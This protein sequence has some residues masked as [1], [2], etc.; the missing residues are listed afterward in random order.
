MDLFWNGTNVNPAPFA[1]HETGHAKPVAMGTGGL[2]LRADGE[3]RHSISN[4]YKLPA[5]EQATR[6]EALNLCHH[7]HDLP[8]VDGIS[9]QVKTGQ[10]LGLLGPNGAGK[11]TTLRIL[12]GVMVPESGVV[13]IEDKSL[14]QHPELSRKIGFLPDQAPLYGDL[15]I[16]EQL[17]FAAGLYAIPAS[18]RKQ[19][20]LRVI[21]L[22]ELETVCDKRID[23]LSKGFRRR[24][25]LAQALLHEPGILIL[26]EP[27]DGLDPL[28]QMAFRKLIESL[29]AETAIVISTHNL[30]EVKNLCTDVIIMDRGSSLF[31]AAVRDIEQPLEQLFTQLIYAGD[32]A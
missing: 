20:I 31:Q 9:L 14:L 22:C 32:Y 24:A 18:Q 30:N 3:S 16:T 29:R 1:C 12:S 28:Q 2:F 6:L 21:E 25:G 17:S 15:S 11:S 5:M 7:Y 10:V 8:V 19:H 23:Q 26:D 4:V 27:G 13:R